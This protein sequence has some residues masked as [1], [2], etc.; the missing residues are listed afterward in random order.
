MMKLRD[1]ARVS[2]GAG[3]VLAHKEKGKH[4]LSGKRVFIAAPMSG[5]EDEAQFRQNRFSVLEMIEHMSNEYK[6]SDVYY[7]GKD[8]PNSTKFSGSSNALDRDIGELSHS[9]VFVLVYPR[10]VRSG[11]LVEAGYAIAAKM[12]TI[13]IVSSREHL[14]YMLKNADK[15]S[16]DDLPPIA[17]EVADAGGFYS[18]FERAIQKLP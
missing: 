15:A 7:A 14:P 4:L 18:A 16:F 12:P 5:F 9:D 6:P 8:I 13:I 10:P 1:S 11:V 2:D 17:I 3:E